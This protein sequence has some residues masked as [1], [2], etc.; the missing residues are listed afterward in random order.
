MQ[1]LI[2][3]VSWTVRGRRPIAAPARSHAA[4]PRRARRAP[5]LR[6]TSVRFGGSQRLAKHRH[7]P[8]VV[9]QNQH[10]TGIER[11]ALVR[12]KALVQ[13]DEGFVEIVWRL[14]IGRGGELQG[15][16]QMI[17]VGTS[18]ERAC[19]RSSACRIR[20]VSASRQRAHTC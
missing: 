17:H 14:E 11:M 15:R 2:P 13:V 6:V 1:G 8:D 18:Q 16:C 4:W 19:A 10:Q 7:R 9:G 12:L 3:A 20:T 5:A